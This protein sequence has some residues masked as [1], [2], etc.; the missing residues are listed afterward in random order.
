MRSIFKSTRDF[1]A[2]MRKRT[3]VSGRLL[4]KKHREMGSTKAFPFL[5]A[6]FYRWAEQWP[7]VCP[8]LAER[9]EDVLL[10]VGDLHVENFGVWR[11]SRQRLVW[12]INDFDDACEL[13]FTSDLVRL[14]ASAALAAEAAEVHVSAKWVCAVILEGYRTGLRTEGK[15]ILLSDRR[16]AALVKLTRDTQEDPKTFWKKKLDAHDNP[17]IDAAEL[18]KGLEDMFRASFP[19]G[20]DLA[21][22]AQKSPGGLGSL[23]RRRFTAVENPKNGVRNG[24]EAKALVPSALYWWTGQEHMPSQ[25]ATLLQHAVRDPDPHFQVHDSWLVRQLAP[26]IAKIEM[27]K[28]ARDKRLVLAP[29]LLR[30]MGRET[31]NI[32]LG[33]RSRDALETLLKGLDRDEQWFATATEGMAACT[34]KDHAEWARHYND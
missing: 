22:R 25:T 26:D 13:P 30:L 23:G 2:W 3:D 4:K 21:F 33:S 6:T 11:D 14:A 7:Q 24:R 1:E 8:R 18:P 17:K 20:A 27:P 12:G 34:R 9:E 19:P 16:H 15:P 5:R 31:A 32:H 29:A 10:A 28:S